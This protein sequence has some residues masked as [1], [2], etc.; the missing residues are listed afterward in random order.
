MITC[1][2]HDDDFDDR[3]KKNNEYYNRFADKVAK[4]IEV[5]DY[6]KAYEIF[7]K[8]IDKQKTI[9]DIGCGTGPHLQEF[10]NRGY[11]GLGIEPSL[12]MRNHAL[13][14]GLEVIDG[15]FENLSRLNLP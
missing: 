13:A 12:Q 15:T 7:L 5:R 1:M 8:N 4:R 2:P 11:K 9:L 3:L 14:R 6:S 10:K